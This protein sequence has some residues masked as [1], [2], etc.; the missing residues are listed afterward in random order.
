MNDD[1]DG[2]RS[3]VAR[4]PV[5]WFPGSGNVIEGGGYALDRTRIGSGL[6][7]EQLIRVPTVDAAL[8]AETLLPFWSPSASV[9]R[10][11]AP[12]FGG[13]KDDA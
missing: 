13:G 4:R 2:W 3:R 1:G 8:E 7:D 6:D 10:N 11:T 5:G 12:I 9:C